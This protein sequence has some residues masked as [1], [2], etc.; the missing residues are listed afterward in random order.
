MLNI[1]TFILFWVI[2]NKDIKNC[3]TVTD[4]ECIFILFRLQA[5][6]KWYLECYNFKCEI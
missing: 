1:E 5:D 4:E 6:E 3:I 2:M